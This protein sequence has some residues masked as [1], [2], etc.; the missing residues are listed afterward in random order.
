MWQMCRAVRLLVRRLK[1]AAIVVLLTV[2]AAACSKSGSVPKEFQPDVDWNAI[3]MASDVQISWREDVQPVLEQRCVVC[4]GCYDAP[5]QLKL[6]SYEGLMRGANPVQ[7]YDG[8][9]IRA[10]QPARLN[11]DATT[12]EEWRARGF[13]PVVAEKSM[14]SEQEAADFMRQSILYRLLRL[15]QLNPQ[16]RTGLVPEALTLGLA[17]KQTCTTQ[18]DVAKFERKNPLWGMPYGMPN[19]A[20]DEYRP[21][22]QWLAQ[23]APP[24]E[25]LKDAVVSTGQIDTWEAFLNGT[26]N[27]E[28]LVSRYIYEHLF[29]GHIHFEGS[30]DRHF[31]RLVRSFTPPGEP[32]Q[33]IPTTRP[34]DD[35]GVEQFWYRLRRYDSI[36]VDKSHVLFELSSKKLER[37]KELFLQPDYAVD[38]L[39]GYELPAASNPFITFANLPSRSRYIF[40]LEDARFYIQGFIKGP[41]CRGQVAIN[42]IEDQFWIVFANPDFGDATTDKLLLNAADYLQMP[43]ATQTFNLIAAY[44]RY[45]KGQKAYLAAKAEVVA[46]FWPETQQEAL[47]VI[48]DG[49][50][51]NKNAALTIFRNFDSAAVEYGLLGQYPETAWV[52][53]YPLLERIHYLLV[54]GFD[55]YGNVGH[56]LNTRLFMDFLRMEGEDN[57]LSFLPSDSRQEIRAGWYQG[58]RSK[59]SRFFQEPM[60]WLTNDSPIEF[61]TDD[62]Q[63]EFYQ[64]IIDHLGPVAGPPDF[65]NRCVGESCFLSVDN[66]VVAEVDTLMRELS[67]IKGEQ[68]HVFPEL[69][70]VHVVVDEGTDV[71]YSL[72]H[73]RQWHNVT[74][75]LENAEAAQRDLSADTLTVLRGFSGSYPNFF[76][77]IQRDE[78]DK[79]VH[80]AVSIQTADDYQLFVAR[81]GVRRTATDFWDEADWFQDRYL[82]E[83]PLAAGIF[84]LNRYENR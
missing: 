14:Q 8:G 53:H 59:R 81:F 84:D 35:P 68:L 3:A 50:G 49:D 74:S 73:N 21:L 51:H 44:T 61:Q 4:H 64:L 54:A 67:R 24:P 30:P 26:S 56:Q 46:N 78:V 12:T 22:V 71:N 77:S 11:I 13:H 40:M 41:V 29:L 33:E 23:G 42:V 5:C 63:T 7:V 70:F 36:I 76:F 1:S 17:R 9:R 20:D 32:V 66:P 83:K 43:S 58:M 80:Q 69:T 55:V 82:E 6:T 10:M 16:P 27:R 57:F 37:Y 45:W 72:M 15:K 65:L 47:D 38:T 48:W 52:I 18:E 2:M 60:H 62:P 25:P 34:F 79:F 75:F 19:L 39:P 31:Y 28:R